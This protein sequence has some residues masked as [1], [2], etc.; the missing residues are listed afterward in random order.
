[1][2][3]R[4]H[5]SEQPG[6]SVSSLLLAEDRFDEAVEVLNTINNKKI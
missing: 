1:M 3:A 2:H 5:A 6:R 4:K